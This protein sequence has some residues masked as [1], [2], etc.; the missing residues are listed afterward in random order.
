MIMAPVMKKLR[1]GHWTSSFI[2]KDIQRYA[3]FTVNLFRFL[4]VFNCISKFL[5][6][7]C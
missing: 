5:H 4:I 6:F 1:V 7:K 3:L 2:H